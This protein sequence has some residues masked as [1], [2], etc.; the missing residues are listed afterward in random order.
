LK[1]KKVFPLFFALFTVATTSFSQENLLDS[2]PTTKEGFVKSETAVINTIDWLENTPLNQQAGKRKQLYATFM[3]WLTNSPTVTIDIETKI[4]PFAR[5]NSDL[6]FMFM[7]GWT[8]YSL[9]NNYSKDAVKCNVAGVKAAI[10]VY[11]MGNGIKKDK[12]MERII[13]IDSKN[14][15]DAWVASQLEQK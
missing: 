3:A 6:L 4:T 11:Q 13:D 14:E 8:K 7:G 9:Q 12:E 5:K 1:L 2:L 15:L 10:K